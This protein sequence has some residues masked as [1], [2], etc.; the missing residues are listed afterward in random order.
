MSNIKETPDFYKQVEEKFRK[1]IY[2]K[3]ILDLKASF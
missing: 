2:I 3:R 1:D